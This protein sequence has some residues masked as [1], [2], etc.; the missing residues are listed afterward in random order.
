MNEELKNEEVKN[1]EVKSGQLVV[2]NVNEL[3]GTR[4]SE[5]KI[6]TTMDLEG[7]E[8]KIYNIENSSADFRI[9]DCKGQSIR[10]M[11]VYIKNIATKLE[12]PEVDENG[13]V[14]KEYEYKK[15]CL[16]ID[17]QGKTYVTASKVFTNQMLGY[18]KMFGV[19]SFKNGVEIKICDKAV[20]GSSNKALGFELI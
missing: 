19:A 2:A 3:T 12:E 10:V 7:N 17:D 11:D 5:V 1:E 9:N 15:I 4:K 20:K 8:K 14:V 6:F 13:E 18:I 16:L